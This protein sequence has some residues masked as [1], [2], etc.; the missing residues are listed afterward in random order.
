MGAD[1]WLRRLLRGAPKIMLLLFW[2]AGCRELVNL[3]GVIT[4]PYNLGNLL[5]D[6][7]RYDEAEQEWRGAIRAD[8]GIAE[9][10][11]NLGSLF[12]ATERPEEV[13]KEFEVAKELFKSQG[14]NE[15][16]KKVEEVLS[17]S[18][19]FHRKSFL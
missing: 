1:V 6:P 19:I 10:H 15:Y 14:R 16:V 8:T 17:H 2:Q 7:E 9:A 5:N 13:K 11:A 12:L 3:S 18:Y 4:A